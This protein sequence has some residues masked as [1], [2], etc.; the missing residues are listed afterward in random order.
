M[1]GLGYGRKKKKRK[2]GQKAIGGESN[3]YTTTEMGDVAPRR[4]REGAI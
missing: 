3:I 4:G 2:K 1:R